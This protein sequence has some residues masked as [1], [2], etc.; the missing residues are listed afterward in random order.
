[1]LVG[2][3]MVAGFLWEVN[4][5]VKPSSRRVGG[6][7]RRYETILYQMLLDNKLI[8]NKL[9]PRLLMLNLIP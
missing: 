2:L 1:V 8:V 9:A 5:R 7:R 4:L 6:Q 3:C